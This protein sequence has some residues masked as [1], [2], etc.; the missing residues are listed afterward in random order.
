[1][2]TTSRLLAIPISPAQ[3]LRPYSPSPC[4]LLFQ[5]GW[6]PILDIPILRVIPRQRRTGVCIH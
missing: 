4:T 5:G 1:M 2:P 6:L 3:E